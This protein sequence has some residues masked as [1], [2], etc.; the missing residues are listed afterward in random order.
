MHSLLYEYALMFSLSNVLYHSW[1]FDG[2][3]DCLYATN[4]NVGGGLVPCFSTGL[5]PG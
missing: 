2:D 3:A 4:E 5:C 1:E